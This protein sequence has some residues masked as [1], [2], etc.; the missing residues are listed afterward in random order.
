VGGAGSEVVFLNDIRLFNSGL[1]N[2]FSPDH[3]G[4][5]PVDIP[6]GSRIS[7]RA[8]CTGTDATDRLVDVIAHG[9][10]Q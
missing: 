10:S 3:Y 8:Q 4:P 2:N 7:A 1:Y 6:A 5:L 9:F